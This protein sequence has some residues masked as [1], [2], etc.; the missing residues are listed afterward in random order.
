MAPEG[1]ESAMD[2]VSHADTSVVSHRKAV[3]KHGAQCLSRCGSE[4]CIG[5][6]TKQGSNQVSACFYMLMIKENHVLFICK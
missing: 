3:A 1:L 2:D 5:T 4:L 6:E